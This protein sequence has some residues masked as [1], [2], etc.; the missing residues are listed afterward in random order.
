[1]KFGVIPP[2]G[3]A[4]VEEGAFAL[5]FARLAEEHG[6]ESIWVVEHVVMATEYR[7]VYPYDPSGRSPF[8]AHVAQ[9]DPL[10]WL[11]WVAAGTERIRLATGVLNVPQRNPLILAKELA[12]LDRLSGGRMEL[13]VGVGW[14]REEADAVGTRFSDRGKRTDE[15]IE[16][17]RTLWR[18]PVASFA[19]DYVHF[20][21]VVCEPRPVQ[22]GGVPIVIGGHSPAA[23][24]RAGRL[25]DGF[26]PLGVAAEALP[27]L[28]AIMADAARAAQR[29][30]AEIALTAIGLPDLNS[31]R[32]CQQIGAA[33]MIVAAKHRE[34][35]E[36]RR[37]FEAFR[38]DVMEKLEPQ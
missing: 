8:T 1:M 13:G 30:P 28:L 38:S 26:Y 24:R 11:A 21:K 33:R 20:D 25:G 5:A 35:D 36:L 2:Y 16:V 34:L 15:Y 29:D 7:S 14:V 32:Y 9:P 18:E 6:F 19:G 4:P 12:S 22:R 10:L 31:A 37:W 23:A 27:G 17:M 3:I